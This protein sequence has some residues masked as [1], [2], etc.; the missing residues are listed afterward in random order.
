MAILAST[1]VNGDL[2]VTGTIV[3]PELHGVKIGED[4]YE[5]SLDD[6]NLVFTKIES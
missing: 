4:Y 1:Q 5:L 2:V 6:G 3:N